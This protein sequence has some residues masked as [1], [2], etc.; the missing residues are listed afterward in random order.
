MH[1]PSHTLSAATDALVLMS[2]LLI[3]IVARCIPEASEVTLPQ[4]R[5]LVVLDANGRMNANTLAGHLGIDPSTCSRLCDRLVAKDLIVREGS[6]DSR[7][8]VVLALGRK[9]SRLV[10][11]AVS[12]RRAE[13]ESLLATLSPPQIRRLV[14]A[15]R[16]LADVSAQSPDDA[17]ALGFV[18]SV[19]SPLRTTPTHRGVSRAR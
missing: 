14:D 13:I 9:G 15:L 18:N 7:R 11:Q 3:G 17:W 10:A 5:A 4:W 6:D 1:G 8:E 12:R 16:P 19:E 2:R